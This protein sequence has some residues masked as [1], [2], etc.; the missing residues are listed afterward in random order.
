ME[1]EVGEPRRVGGP[2][3]HSVDPMRRGALFFT[4]FWGGSP[5]LGSCHVVLEAQRDMAHSQHDV[6]RSFCSLLG[7]FGSLELEPRR[8]GGPTRHGGLPMRHGVLVLRPFWVFWC[9]WARATS[10]WRPNTTWRAPNTTWRAL[11]LPFGLF[12][13]LW[14]GA[15][16]R[17]RSNASWRAPNTTWRALPSFWG[18]WT[19]WA[20]ATSC[21]RP[22]ASWRASNAAWRARFAPFWAVLAPLGSCHVVLEAQYDVEGHNTM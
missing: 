16:S 7:G 14:G 6:A 15:T 18:I 3:R 13:R 11:F 20:R 10:C 19:L 2:T 9:L 21:W 1:S 22:N 8:V 12:W 5:P 17:W 4:S